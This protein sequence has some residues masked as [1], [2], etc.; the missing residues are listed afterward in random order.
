MTSKEL[1][2]ILNQPPAPG[3]DFIESHRVYE[4]EILNGYSMEVAKYGIELDRY[5]PYKQGQLVTVVGHPNAGKTTTMLYLGAL[6]KNKR[7]LIFSAENRISTLHKSFT[8]FYTGRVQ[9]TQ[10]ELNQTRDRIHYI[11][12]RRSF[13]YKEIVEQSLQ[14]IDYGFEWD[15]FLIDPYN[16]LAINNP[17]RLNMHDYHYMV[18][19][20]LRL[21]CMNANKTIFL[22]CH[23]VTESQR[24]KFDANGEKPPPLSSMVEGGAKFINKSDDVMVFHRNPKSII[25]DNKFITQIHVEKV[26]N[27]EFGGEPTPH[28][29]PIMLKYRIDRTGFDCLI[30]QNNT[31]FIKQMSFYAPF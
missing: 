15:W 6:L 22:N 30:T 29:Q 23:T 1:R 2:E 3:Q 4:R 31:Q 25:D 9:I 18:A 13:N 21:F 5:C 14:V 20:Y 7:G 16:A 27:Q 26:R 11:V 28:S 24:D 10:N 12:N 8:R 19:D 17:E